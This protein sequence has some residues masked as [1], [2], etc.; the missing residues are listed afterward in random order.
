[1]FKKIGAGICAAFVLALSMMPINTAYAYDY[2]DYYEVMEYCEDSNY[3][4]K[5]GDA[6]IYMHDMADLFSDSE[7]EQLIEAAGKFVDGEA[8]NVLFLTYADAL[9]RTTMTYSD[10]YMDILFPDEEDNVAF[11][12]DMD[13]R[14][15]YINTMGV[16]LDELSLEEIDECIDAGYEYLPDG[17]YYDAMLRVSC[18][19]LQYVNGGSIIGTPLFGA[20]LG[21]VLPMSTLG[22]AGISAIVAIVLLLNHR[23]ANKKENAQTYLEKGGYYKVAD[24]QENFVNSYTTIDKDYYKPKESSSSG[25]GGGSH[26]SGGGRSHGG[27]G[28]SF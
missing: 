9:G 22:S 23:K 27:G 19:T 2:S 7:E 4:E 15:I 28:R 17:E 3:D 20:R 13:N 8:H 16:Y 25:G 11:V 14:E 1:M 6:R 21:E 12:I 24:K 5:V 18:Y 10:D 26:S